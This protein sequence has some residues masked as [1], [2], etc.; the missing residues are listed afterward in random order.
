MKVIFAE[1]RNARNTASGFIIV[2]ELQLNSTTISK[3]VL[4]EVKWDNNGA[5]NF[6][7]LGKLIADNSP[8][9][10][11]CKFVQGFLPSFLH[12]L[13]YLFIFKTEQLELYVMIVKCL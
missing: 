9:R 12:L 2:S 10:D 8:G 5:E 4:E 3:Q 13:I 1:C 11:Y 6:T 7:N